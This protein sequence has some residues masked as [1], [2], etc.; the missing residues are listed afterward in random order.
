MRDR[1]IAT[2]SASPH[3]ALVQ[4]GRQTFPVL[5]SGVAALTRPPKVGCSLGAPSS[6]TAAL[7][8]CPASRRSS[9]EQTLPGFPASH[10]FNTEDSIGKEERGRR[11]QPL[12]GATAQVRRPG[13]ARCPLS[14]ATSAAG[15][16]GAKSTVT[17]QM[18]DVLPQNGSN[19]PVRKPTPR[20]PLVP[21]K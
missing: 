4:G 21:G 8:G 3:G 12:L 2:R 20:P 18:I 19:T 10:H 16:E 1:A 17:G 13:S 15:E 6:G 14:P 5:G 7:L 11:K 9:S